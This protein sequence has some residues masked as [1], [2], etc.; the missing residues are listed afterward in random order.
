M[1]SFNNAGS[2]SAERVC[3]SFDTQIEI[4]F[5]EKFVKGIVKPIINKSCSRLTL[6]P[7]QTCITRYNNKENGQKQFFRVSSFAL[8]NNGS[9]AGFERHEGG[10]N[11]DNFLFWINY[12]FK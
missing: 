10:V 3:Y 12:P 8:Q 5:G 6:M 7:F 4:C 1:R 11:S 2:R 9:H